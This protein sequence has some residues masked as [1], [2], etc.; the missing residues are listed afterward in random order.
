VYDTGVSARI[1]AVEERIA[2]AACRAGHPF[3]AITLVAVSKTH[4]PEAVAEAFRAGLRAF[5]E[6]RTEEASPKSAAVAALV[7]PAEPPAW[8]MVGH[9]QS[10]KAADVLPWSSMV[11]S[12]DSARLAGRLSRFCTEIG[13]ELEILLEVNVSGEASKYGFLPAELSQAVEHIAGLPALRLRGLMTVAPIV[14]RPEMARPVFARLRQLR[15]ELALRYPTLDFAHL[16]MGMTDDFEVAVE[17][18][19]T[20]VRIGRA[21]FGERA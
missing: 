17:E 6:N 11:H 9:V 15:D 4:G 3:D 16:S 20:L 8:H 7:A 2:A 12:V 19:A 10:R 13:R 18:G 5:G 14:P 21:I 1:A